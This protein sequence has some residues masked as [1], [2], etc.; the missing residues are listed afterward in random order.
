MFE[1]VFVANRGAIA[2]RVIRCLREMGIAS[3]AAYSEADAEAPYVAEADGAIE[4]GPAP[5][6]DS[7]LNQDR[8]LGAL[9][10]SGADALH[11]GYG[12]LAENSG[13]A[14]RVEKSG[15]RFIGPAA[16]WIEAM[17]HKTNARRLMESMGLPVSAA[18]DVL[19]EGTEAAIA[20]A[21]RIGF[22][23]LIKAVRGGGGI[24]MVRAD[25]EIA[26]A[27]N[28]D[29][30]AEMAARAFGDS[31]LFLERFMDR[32]R[33]VE[34]Q[35]LGDAAG[36]VR[37]LYER[38]CSIQRR[39]QKVIEE[40]PAPRLERAFLDGVAARMS[41]ALAKLGYDNIGTVETLH[42][43]ASGLR[44]LE[45]NTR[46]QVEHAV[47]EAVCGIDLVRA[48]ILSAAGARVAEILPDPV[49]LQGHAI[50]AR[51]CAEDPVRFLP[52]PGALKT[53]RPPEGDGI[54]VETGTR[55][56]AAVTPFYDP[57]LAKVVAHGRDR[58]EAIASL[59]GALEAF[60][61]EGVKTNIGFLLRALR[62]A[63]FVAGDVHTGLVHDILAGP[64]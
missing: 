55:E 61:V 64:P 30:A 5:P 47:T 26:L 2:A 48:Q 11:P 40:A 50:E 19:A 33:H 3:V 51:V 35:V 24:G 17:G 59:Q 9:A 25:D 29:R 63:P 23:V 12:F 18:S 62:F 57:L 46:L 49:P 15:C 31:E 43:A 41:G 14:A 52:S 6:L 38:D 22:P 34:F 39:H 56:G 7:Y 1:K 42:D 10:A 53:F 8:V 44:F 36:D 20:E 54:R 37:H 13:F 45:M 32:P 58:N 4:L 16:R 28:L 27:R 21:R 60:A